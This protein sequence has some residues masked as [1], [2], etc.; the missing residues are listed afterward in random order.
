MMKSG[1]I[2]NSDFWIK[3]TETMTDVISNTDNRVGF[4]GITFPSADSKNL[5]IIS[6]LKHSKNKQKR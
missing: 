5:K 4:K 6:T 2:A 1:Y 3:L